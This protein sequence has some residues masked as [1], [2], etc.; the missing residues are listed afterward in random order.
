MYPPRTCLT[1]DL[2]SLLAASEDARAQGQHREGVRLAQQC[3]ELADLAGDPEQ[4]ALA[5]ALLSFHHL[6]LGECEASIAVGRRALLQFV[7]SGDMLAQSRIHSTLALAHFNAELNKEALAHAVESLA[8]ARA[9]GDVLAQCWALTRMGIAHE[10]LDRIEQGLHYT[11][12]AH[13]LALQLNDAEVIFATL[14]NLARGG[15]HLGERLVDRGEDPAPAFHQALAYAEAALAVAEQTGH[16]FYLAMSLAGAGNLFGLL[17]RADQAM[18]YLERALKM[19]VSHGFRSVELDTELHIAGVLRGRGKLEAVCAGLKAQLERFDGNTEIRFAVKA[20]RLLYEMLKSQGLFEDALTHHEQFYLL[21]RREREALADMQSRIL[22]NS[23][24]LDQARVAAERA[25]LEATA[26]RQRAEALDAIAHLDAL[27]GLHNR[28]YV[29]V[30]L[31]RLAVSAQGRG[32]PLCIS[33][34]DIDHFKRVNDLHGHAVGDLVLVQ[35]AQLM[36]CVVGADDLTVRQGGEEFL[37]VFV[38]TP[39]AGAAEKCEVLRLAVQ[40]HDWEAIQAGL[41]ITVS[42]GLSPQEEGETLDKWFARTDAALYRA[43]NQGRN[44]VVHALD[45]QA[46]G[47]G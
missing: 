34:L 8:T 20:H 32:M 13:Q 46:V 12:Q 18:T 44:R 42:L 26:Q 27:T 16:R 2:A 45:V 43:K 23:A 30:H 40:D 7:A 25:G 17:G 10:A 31:P 37:I 5:L 36:R 15:R 29:D 39:M 19:A 4:A 9:C 33:L 6:R 3:A 28:R 14:N 24:E 35:V 22:I 47:A 41:K 38:D 1:A 11:R 21:E